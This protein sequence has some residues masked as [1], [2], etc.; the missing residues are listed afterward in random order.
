MTSKNADYDQLFACTADG[1]SVRGHQ[2]LT[3][4]DTDFGEIVKCTRCHIVQLT[5]A[6]TGEDL[7]PHG[8]YEIPNAHARRDGDNIVY[9]SHVMQTIGDAYD[10]FR[11]VPGNRDG[12]Y[13]TQRHFVGTLTAG[14]M[15]PDEAHSLYQRNRHSILEF[16]REFHRTRSHQISQLPLL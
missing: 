5:P 6:V 7:F 10:A 4:P 8:P 16:H 2:W 11:T 9:A 15:N 14:G 13:P 12:S 1:V 3:V